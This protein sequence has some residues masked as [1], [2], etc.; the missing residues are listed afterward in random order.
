MV[1]SNNRPISIL[2]IFSKI[3]ERHN[4]LLNF[5]NEYNTINKNQVGLRNNHATYM[6]LLIMLEN[7]TNALDNGEYPTRIF[8]DFQKAFDTVDHGILLDK[9]YN[10]EI[11]CIV[12]GWSSSY[13]F[14][15]FQIVSYNSCESEPNKTTCGVP[16]G[17]ILSPLLFLL[18]INDLPMV[19]DLFIPISFAD[20]TSLFCTGNKLNILVDNIN[21]ELRKVYTWV[22]ANKLC[23]NIEKANCMLLPHNVFFVPWS[24]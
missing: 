11:R 23:L 24:I 21:L 10:Y 8:L 20:D 19:S 13:L 6:P 1:F 3:L 12:L 15:R 9:L 2:P 22:R 4:R 14:N 16:K 5:L 17:S 7:I 18:Y